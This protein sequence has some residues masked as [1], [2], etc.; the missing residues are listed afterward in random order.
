VATANDKGR[1]LEL[2][3]GKSATLKT[4]PLLS[5]IV[6]TYKRLRE[7]GLVLEAVEKQRQAPPFE[8]IIVDNDTQASAKNLV[9]P[10]IR[11]NSDWKYEVNSTN[12]VSKARNLGANCAKAEWL[13]FLDDDCVP[14]CQWLQIAELIIKSQPADGLIFGGGYEGES[15]QPGKVPLEKEQNLPVDAYLVE[16]NLFF[17]RNEYIGLGGM[18][19]ELGPSGIRFG[20]HE[21]TELQ[22]RHIKRYGKQHR[23]YYDPRLAVH[24]LAANPKNKLMLACQSGFDAVA[25]FNTKEEKGILNSLYHLFKVPMA[26]VRVGTNTVMQRE[27]RLKASLYQLGEVLGHIAQGLSEVG[28]GIASWIRFTNNRLTIMV[29]T[30]HDYDVLQFPPM[31]YAQLL[32]DRRPFAAGKIGTAEILGLDYFDRFF[33]GG[34]GITSWV[35]P[36]TRLA[37]NA[38]FFPV[39]LDAYRGWNR[40]MR[41]SIAHLDFVCLWQT[42]PFLRLYESEFV[43]KNAE[44]AQRIP[45]AWLGKSI[46]HEIADFRC[47]VISPFIKTMQM[48]LPR[49]RQ[50]HDP[51]YQ[52]KINWD[53]MAS[54]IRFLRCPLQWHLEPSPYRSWAEGLE[55][56]SGKVAQEQFD[57]ALIGAGAWSLPLAAQIKKS[58]RS[59]IHTGGETQL[60][61]GIK[62]QRWNHIDFY[63]SAWVSVLPEETPKLRA[64]IDDACYW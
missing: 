41:A 6:V 57:V 16:G 19:P 2:E 49:M 12:N 50:I 53:K 13:A 63:N 39:E 27:M 22:L 54:N 35:R 11:K 23:R 10:F 7:L 43:S 62:G 40:E 20:Y 24:H 14:P 46:L 5:V 37:N 8:V 32:R 34:L 36:A 44:K 56:L 29:R 64:K 48:Q 15:M 4:V 31:S 58:G 55:I 3:F 25:A 52:T 17:R 60:F 51:E 18:R 9:M 21:G 38:G 28:R 61:F 1:R 59:A 33:Q 26:L 47:L 42:D 30:S 45:M